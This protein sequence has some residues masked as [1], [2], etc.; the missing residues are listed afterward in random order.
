MFSVS[1]DHSDFLDPESIQLSVANVGSY[2]HLTKEE[3]SQVRWLT[4]VIPTLWEAEVG[5][6]PE[7]R[8]LKPAWPTWQNP[9]STKITKII[10]ARW[11]MPVIP[12]LWEAKMDVSP[13]VRSSRPAWPTW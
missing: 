6:S 9:I 10:W 1:R 5:G 8:S 12:T 11:L 7:V 2:L 4:P 3:A 13:E